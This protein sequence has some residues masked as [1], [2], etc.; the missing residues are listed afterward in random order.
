MPSS[1][2]ASAGLLPCST[3]KLVNYGL[4]RTPLKKQKDKLAISSSV[5]LKLYIITSGMIKNA[6]PEATG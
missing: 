2:R 5:V 6:N 4:Q 1:L 3:F